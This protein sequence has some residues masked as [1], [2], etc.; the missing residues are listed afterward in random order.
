MTLKEKQHLWEQVSQQ[1]LDKVSGKEIPAEKLD[2]IFTMWDK[3]CRKIQSDS[4]TIAENWF[5]KY[6]NDFAEARRRLKHLAAG[7]SDAEFAALIGA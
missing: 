4:I 3:I 5:K 7:M 2:G 6:T 1:F